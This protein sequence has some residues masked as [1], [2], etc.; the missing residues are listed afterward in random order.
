[1]PGRP[2]GSVPAALPGR[3]SGP[4]TAAVPGRAAVS[5]P[6][7][8]DDDWADDGRTADTGD[9]WTADASDGWTADA[10][11]GWT[12]DTGWTD[13]ADNGWTGDDDQAPAPAPPGRPAVATASVAPP[14]GHTAVARIPAVGAVAP[15]TGNASAP[16]AA[17]SAAVAS[18]AVPSQRGSSGVPP[19]SG[20]AYQAGYDDEAGTAPHEFG[21]YGPGPSGSAWA[22]RSEP[23]PYGSGGYETADPPPAEPRPA[24]PSRRHAAPD[25]GTDLARYGLGSPAAPAPQTYG[26][27]T[28]EVHGSDYGTDYGSD[29]GTD[30]GTE[31]TGDA[32]WTSAGG[33]QYADPEAPSAFGIE[34]S[35]FFAE[36]EAEAEVD[37]DVE[38]A[39]GAHEDEPVQA[40]DYAQPA[41]RYAQN[42]YGP[43]P[44]GP[45]H[46]WAPRS[47][48]HP[49]RW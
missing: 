13:D 15:V 3:S 40:A 39:A 46:G 25:T 38:N 48:E 8:T 36:A 17:G 9:G 20:S 33:Y 14:G 10:S 26:T 45:H 27:A 16:R 32:T 7:R 42:G 44:M 19:T 30:F 21:G 49:G 2:P 23:A 41:D 28:P 35:S 11:D 43:D 5:V 47:Q 18:A 4:A 34:T 37:P 29:F 22:E 12:D 24:R 31:Q 6:G 1:M